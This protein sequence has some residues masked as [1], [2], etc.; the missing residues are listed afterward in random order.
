MALDPQFQKM[1]DKI[2][3]LRRQEAAAVAEA[4]RLVKKDKYHAD[5]LDEAQRALAAAVKAKEAH[6]AKLAEAHAAIA[7]V[8]ARR[9]DAE[10][11]Y[12]SVKAQIA[13]LVA[14]IDRSIA[15]IDASIADIENI[16][17]K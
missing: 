15:E 11:A 16:L 7:G 1:I 14:E 10:N 13:P 5:K 2:E 6:D 8:A 12:E 9:R 17:A 3:S 4:E